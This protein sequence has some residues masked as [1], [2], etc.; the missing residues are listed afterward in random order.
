MT[1]YEELLEESRFKIQSF[2]ESIANEYVPKM[3]WALHDENP[4]LEP[5]DVKDRIK[6]DCVGIWSKCTLLDALPDLKNQKTSRL[7]Q[8]EANSAAF[9]A[10]LPQEM[11]TVPYQETYNED[12]VTEVG[13]V[14]VSNSTLPSC[15]E[16]TSYPD[17]KRDENGT[18]A[19]L[20]FWF[21]LEDMRRY[22]Q[23]SFNID[24]IKDRL[25]FNLT[26]DMNSGVVLS[27][28]IGKA[29]QVSATSN[30]D[31]NPNVRYY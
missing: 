28:S 9:S 8:K 18:I 6:K 30:G 7:R 25:W 21:P 3:F 2:L 29:M 14:A 17:L 1:T 19:R 5:E 16:E 31:E 15:L 26:V 27:A 24:K 23:K 13:G 10:A 4:E 20:D 22:L 11:I 12:L